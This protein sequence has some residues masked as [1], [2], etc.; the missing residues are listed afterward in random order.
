MKKKFSY[1]VIQS[2]Q[3]RSVTYLYFLSSPKYQVSWLT[4]CSWYGLPQTIQ[5]YQKHRF[6]FWI[7]Y[8]VHNHCN[9]KVS[10][11]ILNMYDV[12]EI[13]H[14]RLNLSDNY[15][16][17]HKDASLS[18]DKLSALDQYFKKLHIYV[19]IPFFVNVFDYTKAPKESSH[20]WAEKKFTIHSIQ[21]I[22]FLKFLFL[23]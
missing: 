10:Q 17:L 12:C 13:I 21:Y 9:A 15:K 8:N 5:N 22:S 23:T 16:T 4:F 14:S 6:V 11:F 1:I 18:I 3:N 7:F 19:Q 20:S 2:F